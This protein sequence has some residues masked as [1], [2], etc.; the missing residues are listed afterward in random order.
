MDYRFE[1]YFRSRKWKLDTES[2]TFYCGGYA[3]MAFKLGP[4]GAV[5]VRGDAHDLFLPGEVLQEEFFTR[6]YDEFI[7][8]HLANADEFLEG[9]DKQIETRKKELRE[10][11]LQLA[12]D[13]SWAYK[14][15][16]K[17]MESLKD[18][19]K[20]HIEATRKIRNLKSASQ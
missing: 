12:N 15:H 11:L 18:R 20:A 7:A 10:R 17:C 4:D 1:R 14:D 5:V 8:R 13:I 9:L 16:E 19:K 6:M 3:E 2:L